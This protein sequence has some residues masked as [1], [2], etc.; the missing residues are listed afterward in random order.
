MITVGNQ[1]IQIRNVFDIVAT[2]EQSFREIDCDDKILWQKESQFAIQAL[3]ANDYLN[4]IAWGNRESLKNAIINVASIGISLNPASKHAY[5][6]PRDNK[7]CLDISYMGLLHL[8]VKSGS[9][10]WGQSKLVGGKESCK[11]ERKHGTR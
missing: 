1:E 9:V 3:Q 8:A 2:Q 7:V 11:V 5:L 4:K 6:V 10:A